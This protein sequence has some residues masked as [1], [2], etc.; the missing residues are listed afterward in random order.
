M[1]LTLIMLLKQHYIKTAFN[2]QV[3]TGTLIPPVHDDILTNSS[4]NS[5]VIL[6][7]VLLSTMRWSVLTVRCVQ[8]VPV[9]CECL[10]SPVASMLTFCECHLTFQESFTL[11]RL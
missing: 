8:F 10:I 5:P 6:P 4:L 9:C 2:T 3:N 1:V 7:A 11:L